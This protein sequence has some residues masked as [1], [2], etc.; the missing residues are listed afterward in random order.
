MKKKRIKPCRKCGGTDI[1]V[2]DCG[3]SSFNVGGVVCKSCGH[4]VR[5]SPC[6]LDPSNELVKAWNSNVPSAEEKMFVL[7]SAAKLAS[8]HVKELREAWQTGAIRESDGK[9]GERSNRNVE[10][11][12]ALRKAI[13]MCESEK[14]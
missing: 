9:G 4:E 13:E 6:G 7:L 1:H 5:V 8:D 14:K 12:V 2:W 10:V 3:Y 11:D